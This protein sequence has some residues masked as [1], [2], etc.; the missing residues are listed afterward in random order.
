MLSW[1]WTPYRQIVDNLADAV[2]LIDPEQ[3]IK[4]WNRAAES[5]SGHAA[6]EMTGRSLGSSKLRFE[7][8][9]GNEIQP[10]EY[11]A[12]LCLQ[13]KQTITKSF[14]M[15]TK[16]N[17]RIPVEEIAVPLFSGGKVTGVIAAFRDISDCVRSVETR[18]KS[19][20]KERLIPICGW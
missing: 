3:R 20:M 4:Y 2:Y 14:F 12:A 18:L 10:F 19:E 1:R 15:K 8:D 16:D 13:K 11:P 7:D 5:L 17:V 9:Q 6:E